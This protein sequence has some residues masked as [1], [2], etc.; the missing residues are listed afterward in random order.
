MKKTCLVILAC[1][2]FLDGH[3]QNNEQVVNE[4]IKAYNDKDSLKTF[5]LLHNDFVELWEK[6]TAIYSKN[7][8]S[9]NYAW[10]TVMNDF[11]EIQINKADSNIVETIYTYYSDRDKLL[12][13][14]PFKSKRVYDIRNGQIVKIVGGEFDGYLEYHEP[15][16]EQYEVFFKWVSEHHKLNPSDFSFDK[17]GAEKLKELIIEYKKN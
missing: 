6:D 3:S 8:Y 12:G 16:R 13:V 2:L 7:D 4:F 11:E 10:G 17:N 1:F 15:R 14:G 5:G 9:E